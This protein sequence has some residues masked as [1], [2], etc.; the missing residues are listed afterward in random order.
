MQMRACAL[1]SHPVYFVCVQIVGSCLSVIVFYFVPTLDIT[2]AGFVIKKPNQEHI[3]CDQSR[4]LVL[5]V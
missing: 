3:L 2:D 1:Y 4:N 5:F